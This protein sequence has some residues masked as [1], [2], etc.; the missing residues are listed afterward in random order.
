M[1]PDI[2]KIATKAVDPVIKKF[3]G[4]EKIMQEML[5]IERARARAEG[6]TWEEIE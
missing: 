1:G 2:N 3:E 4:L 6:L 5:N